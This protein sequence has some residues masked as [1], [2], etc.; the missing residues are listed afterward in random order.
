LLLT[1]HD[2]RT[3]RKANMHFIAT[4]LAKLG[5]MR[6][7]SLRY[8]ALSKRTHDMRVFLDDRANRVDRV[9]GVDCYLWKTWIHPF[10]TRRRW[11]RPLENLLFRWSVS[12][13][14]RTLVDWMRQADV[15][16]FE[17]G[18]AVL[19][20]ELAARVNPRAR[21]VY[22]A[23]DDLGT[24]GVADFVKRTFDRVAASMDALCLPSPR[25]AATMPRS[26]N[27]FFV[28]H[29]L[30]PSIAERADPSPYATRRN[31][32]SVGSML[33][34]RTF[35]TIAAPAFPDV[36]FHV[37]GAGTTDLGDLPA[38]VR[39]FDEMP[40]EET[41]RYIKHADVGI[42]PYRAQ[43]VPDYLAHTSMKLMQYAFFGLP[44]VC[45]IQAVGS[46]A[47]RFGYEPGSAASIERALR[48]AFAAS[49]SFGATQF[50]DWS[51]VTRRL[52]DPRAFGDTALAAD[53]PEVLS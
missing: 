8:S 46:V 40:H 34:D 25:M 36:T 3:P 42:A 21:R 53:A 4:E 22:I 28:P 20:V 51:E 10:N 18:S 48:G 14:P 32:V 15:I 19:F 52:V 44:A 31:A 35:F 24:I 29:G 47:S 12:H 2:F 49:G 23:S 41:L 6:F 38:N 7:F 30:D 43:E 50:M 33:F 17:S 13:P 5:K 45:P 37:I 26:A 16:F 9:D 27:K 39:V 1:A 11:L